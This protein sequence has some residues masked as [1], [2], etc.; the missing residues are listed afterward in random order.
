MTTL[1]NYRCKSHI[2]LIPGDDSQIPDISS[3]PTPKGVQLKV[4]SVP[5]SSNTSHDTSYQNAVPE[6]RTSSG[7]LVTKPIRYRGVI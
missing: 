2:K 6:Q 3:E 7:R 1:V 5:E 4:T